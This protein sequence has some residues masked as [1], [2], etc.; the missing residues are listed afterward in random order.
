MTTESRTLKHAAAITLVLALAAAAGA[1]AGAGWATQAVAAQET[2]ADT[3][4]QFIVDWPDW[5]WTASDIVPGA[6]IRATH[7]SDLRNAAE[8]LLSRQLQ[9]GNRPT[10]CGATIAGYLVA[11]PG[12]HAYIENNLIPRDEW[13]DEN[14]RIYLEQLRMEDRIRVDCLGHPEQPGRP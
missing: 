1:T 11:Y 14:R 8:H 2:G 5:T 6:A 12:I 13:T 10:H 7:I 4:G 9:S 3:R